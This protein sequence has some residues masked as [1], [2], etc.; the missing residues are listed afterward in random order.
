MSSA[1]L[2]LELS[3]GQRLAMLERGAPDGDPIFFCHGWPG[4]SRQADRLHDA[5]REFG[6]RIISFDR[7]GVA[8]SSHPMQRTLLDWPPMLAEAAD[9]L[10]VEKFRLVGVSGGGPYALATAW[11]MSARVLGVAIVCGAPPIAELAERR[12]LMPAYRLLLGLYG[13]SPRAARWLF[14]ALRPVALLPLPRALRPLA[15]K[16]VGPVD[17]TALADPVLFD[18]CYD[19]FRDAWSGSADGVF[20]DARI[21]AERWGFAPEEIKVPVHFWHGRGDR[22]FAWPLADQLAARIP[23]ARVKICDDEGHYSL[24][25]RQARAILGGL[26]E[27]SLLPAAS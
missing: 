26:R 21:Y 8:Q 14:R 3:G 7:P 5:A 23:G 18:N 22:N 24:P 2:F 9:Q 11:A 10:G 13:K 12:Q 19:S 15:L 27:S 25:F 16:I 17:A 20:D 1:T 4:T 6:F